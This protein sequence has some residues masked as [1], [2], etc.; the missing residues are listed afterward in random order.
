[1]TEVILS[2]IEIADRR[3]GDDL[4][5]AFDSQTYSPS[6]CVYYNYRW[7]RRELDRGRVV[8]CLTVNPEAVVDGDPPYML[9]FESLQ[10]AKIYCASAK[11]D[12]VIA[13]RL[14]KGEGGFTLLNVERADYSGY[15]MSLAFASQLTGLPFQ[16]MAE[17]GTVTEEPE[18]VAFKIRMLRRMRRRG[19]GHTVEASVLE[20]EIGEDFRQRHFRTVT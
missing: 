12:L 8:D 11:A 17:G 2:E 18:P 15:L 14:G 4:S 5:Q 19:R 1:M 16:Q 7:G 20:A 6:T 13:T 3:T 10:S 9:Q